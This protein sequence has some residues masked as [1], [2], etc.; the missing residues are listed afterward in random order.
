MRKALLRR[1]VLTA[2]PV[3]LLGCLGLAGNT[4]FV[5]PILVLLCL[6]LGGC[7][8][9][10]LLG[11]VDDSPRQITFGSAS[12]WEPA[13]SPDGRFI[14]FSLRTRIWVVSL[15]SGFVERVEGIESGD[16][17]GWSG[18]AAHLVYRSRPRPG[19]YGIAIVPLDGGAP[20]ER[21]NVPNGS[22][23]PAWSPDGQFIAFSRF[24]EHN[25]DIWIAP[26]SG[27]PPT[28]VTSHPEG[29]YYPAWSP[30]SEWLAFTS[31]R[32][33]PGTGDIWILPVAAPEQA[34]PITSGLRWASHPCWSPDGTLIAFQSTESGNDDI[35]IV[36]VA[37]GDPVNVTNDPSRD[38]HPSFSANGDRIAFS[39]SRTGRTHVWTMV[40]PQVAPNQPMQ[41][42][43][44]A[45]RWRDQ[46][47]GGY[48]LGSQGDRSATH[49]Y[50]LRRF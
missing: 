5:L 6:G 44:F 47:L 36:P 21:T 37:G 39:S 35:W 24:A 1:V 49:A 7:E 27:E 25:S 42:S 17:P 45:R 41:R 2:L 3:S 11:P 13:W 15:E 9:E 38:V 28:Q 40:V 20:M 23:N 10:G 34:R 14:A 12:E 30:D 4:C 43:A 18:D 8:H 46:R 16:Q 33:R 50:A 29:D 26:V 22:A 19:A 48:D 31:G 32:G